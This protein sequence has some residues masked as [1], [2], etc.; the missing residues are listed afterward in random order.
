MPQDHDYVGLFDAAIRR[1]FRNALHLCFRDPFLAVF[2]FRTLRRQ[3]RAARLRSALADQGLHVP[4]FMIAS[5]TNR[6]N[7]RCQGCYAQAHHRPSSGEMSGEKL[8][9]VLDEARQLGISLVLLAG[10]SR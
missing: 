3:K 7:L 9:A 6:C 5:V 10:G 8:R 4:A 1:L 2:F